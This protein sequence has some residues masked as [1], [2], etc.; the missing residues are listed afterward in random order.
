MTLTAAVGDATIDTTGGDIG[1]A[2][3]LSGG[4]GLAKAGSGTL[5]LSA[6]NT[7]YGNTTVN[8]GTLAIGGTLACLAAAVSYYGNIAIAAGAR[9]WITWRHR[10]RLDHW[11][12]H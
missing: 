9:C 7:Y 4:G 8:A 6:S 3:A 5:T 12:R 1:L 2:G 11:R 10:R